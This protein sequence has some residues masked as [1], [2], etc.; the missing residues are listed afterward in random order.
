MQCKCIKK[1][2][3]VCLQKKVDWLKDKS[4]AV[5]DN[6]PNPDVLAEEIDE[7]GESALSSFQQIIR[8]LKLKKNAHY[9]S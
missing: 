2:V 3:S 5:L 9:G 7:N 8:Q 4:L 1:F 6:L